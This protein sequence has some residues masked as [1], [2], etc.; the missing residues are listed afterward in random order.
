M[1]QTSCFAGKPYLGETFTKPNCRGLPVGSEHLADPILGSILTVLTN[2]AQFMAE[3][4]EKD[5]KT[6]AIY[7]NE[8][9]QPFYAEGL[10]EK[11]QF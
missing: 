11:I 5:K 10:T 6:G 8:M 9:G 7:S 1:Y 4:S 3:A 2:F